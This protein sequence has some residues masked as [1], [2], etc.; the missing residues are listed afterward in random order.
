MLKTLTTLEADCMAKNITIHLC[1]VPDDT[2]DLE[3]AMRKAVKD[4]ASTKEGKEAYDKIRKINEDHISFS[5][6]IY[7]LPEE[8]CTKHG[9]KVI[10]RFYEYDIL[11]NSVDP[12]EITDDDDEY[13]E[14][15]NDDNED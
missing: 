15:D 6:A 14:P 9:F 8:F 12:T 1:E 4:Y 11:D 7:L 10:Q 13:Y 3:N 2:F 5:D